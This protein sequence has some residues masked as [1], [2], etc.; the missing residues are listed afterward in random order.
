VRSRATT[1]AQRGSFVTTASAD[2]RVFSGIIAFITGVLFSNWV[3][4]AVIV[5]EIRPFTPGL[6]FK[7]E[8]VVMIAEG[9]IR[10]L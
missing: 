1:R 4:G 2:S 9:V 8:R 7:L 10:P 5:G 6:A 3:T